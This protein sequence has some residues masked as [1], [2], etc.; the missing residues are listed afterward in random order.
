MRLTGRDAVATILV[1]MIAIPYAGYLIW[2]S[3][4][5]IEDP[6]GMAA[7]G[8]ILGVIAAV[9]GGFIALREGAANT[10]TTV[11][12][13]IV[14]LGLGIATLVSEHLFDVTS[15]AIVLGAF[16][17]SIVALWALALLRHGGVIASETET[18]S[19]L[20]HV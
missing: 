17:A 14:S 11:T 6:T 15:R 2:G 13:G 16:M 4:P 1:A 8:L 7:V 12:L 10:V 19:R 20:G 3:M 18:T 9:A 5:F